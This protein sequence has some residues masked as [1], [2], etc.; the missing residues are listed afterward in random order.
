MIARRLRIDRK[1]AMLDA[2]AIDIARAEKRQPIR[3]EIAGCG[4]SA[5]EFQSPLVDA[6]AVSAGRNRSTAGDF[7]GVTPKGD[8]ARRHGSSS[9]L[10]RLARTEPM[11]DTSKPNALSTS[12][13]DSTVVSCFV[14]LMS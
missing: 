5:F 14:P 9:S 7:A 10:A 2:P 13:F 6:L 8:N 12:T 11:D 3:A 1:P 4:A